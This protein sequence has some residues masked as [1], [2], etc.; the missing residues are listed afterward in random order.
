MKTFG[1]YVRQLRIEKD[2]TLRE[3][4]R[5]IEVDPSNW[6]KVE[7]SISPAPKSKIVLNQIEKTLTLNSEQ[8]NDLYV[9]AFVES[10]PDDLRPSDY[11]LSKLPIFLRTLRGGKPS[12][13]ELRMLIQKILEN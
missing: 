1:E 2:I 3:F 10:I 11:C 4:C 13:A 9:L 6:S 7:N 12:E 5:S 8:K